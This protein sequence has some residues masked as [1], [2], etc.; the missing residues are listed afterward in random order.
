MDGSQLDGIA[1]ALAGSSSRRGALKVA[2]AGILGAAGLSG[3]S[4]ALASKDK[5]QG[6]TCRRSKECG[7]GLRCEIP[8]G[9]DKGTCEYRSGTCGKINDTCGGNRQC[10]G[11]LKCTRKGNDKVCRHPNA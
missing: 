11:G 8:Y 7:S 3:A 5:K 4:S 1:R 6:A 10:C 2:A 9:A